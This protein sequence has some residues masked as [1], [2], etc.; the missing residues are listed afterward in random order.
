MFF[1]LI[2]TRRATLGNEQH[3]KMVSLTTL[4]R[5]TEVMHQSYLD[6]F[7]AAVKDDEIS[8]DSKCRLIPY[9]ADTLSIVRDAGFA[10]LADRYQTLFRH[11]GLQ[12]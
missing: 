7:L 4:V 12:L 3:L 11:H 5:F 1:A 6:K 2:I 8:R 10:P 9:I